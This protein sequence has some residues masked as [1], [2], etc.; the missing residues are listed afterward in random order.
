MVNSSLDDGNFEANL[1]AATS[2]G[3]ST[4]PLVFGGATVVNITNVA[5][6]SPS[7]ACADGSVVNFVTGICTPCPIGTY[8][9]SPTYKVCTPCGTGNTT[10]SAGLIGIEN[11]K[12]KCDIGGYCQNG[13][14]CN[15]DKYTGAASCLCSVFY[16]GDQCQMR[17]APARELPTIIAAVIGAIGAVL[18]FILLILCI[19]ICMR[20]RDKKKG[21]DYRELDNVQTQPHPPPPHQQNQ[22]NQQ[23]FF[24]QGYNPMGVDGAPMPMRGGT[25]SQT[26]A[27]PPAPYMFYED[28]E[29]LMDMRS[30]SMA[31]GYGQNAGG[32]GATFF[33]AH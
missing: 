17:R 14:S 31:D 3:N 25:P 5:G 22:M 2:A 24:N 15:V 16:V 29:E 13:G 6:S 9:E 19:C 11:C 27:H 4:D 12:G 10:V 23:M 21:G 26:L 1:K 18:L 32:R 20:N 33:S 8:Q 30:V 7:G 28:K